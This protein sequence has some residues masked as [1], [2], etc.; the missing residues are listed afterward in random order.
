MHLKWLRQRARG[1]RT[2]ERICGWLAAGGDACRRRRWS[3]VPSSGDSMEARV[4]VGRDACHQ[5]A[6][7][8]QLWCGA[9]VVGQEGSWKV[10]EG[11]GGSWTVV[12]GHGGSWKVM[13]GRGGSWRVVEGRGRSRMGSGEMPYLVGRVWSAS[14]IPW[15]AQST[16]PSREVTKRRNALPAALCT[17]W[18]K[19]FEDGDER[20]IV[21]RWRSAARGLIRPPPCPPPPPPC[22]PPPATPPSSSSSSEVAV[23]GGGGRLRVSRSLVAA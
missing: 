12:E 9:V 1:S 23:A 8:G 5:S 13:E 22:P 14:V 20:S 3:I 2:K 10:M 17:W 21:G 4:Q 11:R 7:A 6:N 18:K 16:T 19:V 15:A